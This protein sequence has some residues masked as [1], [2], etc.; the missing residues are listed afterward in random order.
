MNRQNNDAQ[1]RAG[2]LQ[3]GGHFETGKSWQA[4]VKQ[5]DIGFQFPVQPDG[6]F[7]VGGFTRDLDCWISGQDL[8]EPN[9]NQFVVVNDKQSDHSSPFE[10]RPFTPGGE[11]IISGKNGFVEG[12]ERIRGDF[13]HR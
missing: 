7:S 10:I 12:L 2:L 6:G 8:A 3:P 1:T 11:L 5:N 9:P 13:L 4:D